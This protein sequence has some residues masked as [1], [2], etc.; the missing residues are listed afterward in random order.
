MCRDHFSIHLT[1]CL[2]LGL[3]PNPNCSRTSLQIEAE[4]GETEVRERFI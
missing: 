3:L 4:I 2:G 1:A